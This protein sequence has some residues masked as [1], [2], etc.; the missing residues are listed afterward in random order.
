MALFGKK[1]MVNSQSFD[2][3]ALRDEYVKSTSKCNKQFWYESLASQNKTLDTALVELL[4]F[5]VCPVI[6]QPCFRNTWYIIK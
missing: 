5:L 2:L 6:M 1:P 4:H 3:L